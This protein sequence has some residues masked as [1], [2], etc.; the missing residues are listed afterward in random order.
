MIAAGIAA[1]FAVVA[2]SAMAVWGRMHSRNV[3]IV[4]AYHMRLRAQNSGK[5]KK[6]KPLPEEETKAAA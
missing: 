6:K 2:A 1:A 5:K 4:L 3:Q